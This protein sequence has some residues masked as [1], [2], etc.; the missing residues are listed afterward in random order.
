MSRAKLRVA[1]IGRSG[2]GN[3]GHQLDLAFTGHERAEIVA[4]ADEREA[5]LREARER[6]GA[7]QGYI[8][9]RVML[10]RERP[11]LVVVAPRWV[12]CHEEM[13]LAALDAGAH[14]Y[15]EKPIAQTLEQAD[16]MVAAAK[17]RGLLFGVALP[18]VHEPRFARLR[19]LLDDGLIGDVL[20]LKG[21]CKWDHRSGGQD[22]TVLGVHFADMIRRLGGAAVSCTGHLIG[23]GGPRDGDEQ[24]G[25]VD[26]RGMWGAYGL[27]SGLLA[28]IESWPCGVEDRA[29]HPYRLEVHG[30][31]GI[32]VHRAPYADHS[33]WH[34]DGP[35]TLPGESKWTRIPT[36]PIARYG[37]YHRLAAADYL[38]AI[39]KGREPACSGE[40]GTAALEM[41]HAVYAS[42]LAGT[43][44]PLPLA[45]RAHPLLRAATAVA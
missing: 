28:T 2:R 39:D 9:F 8:D 6:T 18:A 15:C 5:G 12:D 44:V 16:A 32:L 23:G 22:F 35:V 30:T 3:Y 34:H 4:V 36:E 38:D 13:A 31:K 11:D 37:D 33:L 42:V 20:Q 10:E 43:T 17:A 40:D 25:P 21:L 27:R 45:E 7:P 24:V 41:V 29:R 1:V 19:A 14:V 26:G